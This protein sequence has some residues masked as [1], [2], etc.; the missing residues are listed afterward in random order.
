MWIFLEVVGD[1]GRMALG[2]RCRRKCYKKKRHK[3]KENLLFFN[4]WTILLVAACHKKKESLRQTSIHTVSSS[5]SSRIPFSSVGNGK[6]LVTL[7]VAMGCQQSKLHK[8][9]CTWGQNL[10]A[11]LLGSCIYKE[12]VRSRH[13]QWKSIRE[14]PLGLMVGNSSVRT[15]WQVHQHNCKESNH[16]CLV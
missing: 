15:P 16:C 6:H 1:H 8:V 2:Q 12:Q 7:A 10:M 9:V 4:D 3:K 14:V 13:T 5:Q 11:E